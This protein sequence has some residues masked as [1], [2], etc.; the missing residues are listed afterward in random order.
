MK[1]ILLIMLVIATV[2]IAACGSKT[3]NT[4]SKI[5]A[6]TLEGIKERGKLIAGVKYDVNLFGLKDPKSGEIQ[7][8]EVDLMQELAKHIFGEDKE[9]NDILEL[10]QVSS[11]TRMELATNGEIDLAAANAS[12]T[13]EREKIVDF[14]DSY[15]LAGQSL[16]VPKGS[17]IK[18]IDDLNAKTTVIAIK[19]STSEKT[20]NDSAPDAKVLLF[21]DNA[22]AFSALKS[23][24]GDTLIND[25]AILIGMQEQDENFELTGGL[26]SNEPYRMIFSP[27]NDE[28]REYVNDF[29]QELKDSGKLA[30]IHEKWFGEAPPEDIIQENPYL[31]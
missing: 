24:K 22:Q 3:D 20:I 7:G 9:I 25:N 23:G 17:D 8:Y 15:F 11:K 10:K 31:Q 28:F 14:S 27:E 29:L 12:S 18:S 1:K 26:I 4:N 5:A 19:G 21:D 6:G 16:L 13:E 2:V 30:E